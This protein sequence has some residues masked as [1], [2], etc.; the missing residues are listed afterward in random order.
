MS[1]DIKNIEHLATLARIELSPK[2]KK[3]FAQQLGDILS[4]FEKLKQLDTQHIPITS[5]S[6]DLVNINR[7]DEVKDCDQDT[8]QHIL[9]NAPNTS[10]NYFKTGKI[11]WVS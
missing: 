11:L 4:Y 10:G 7:S 3:K 9:D 8:Q 2:E 1:I 5:Q 6:I